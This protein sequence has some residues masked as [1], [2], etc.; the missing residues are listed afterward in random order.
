MEKLLIDKKELVFGMD[1]GTRTVV[2]VVGI[3]EGDLLRV[4]DVEVQEHQNRSMMDGQVHD[5]NGV[6][7]TANTVKIK[8]EERLGFK[9]KRVCI[10]AAGRVLR[11]S[12]IFVEKES[13]PIHEISKDQISTLEIEALL[14]AQNEFTYG[15]SQKEG[16]KFYC[17]GHTITNYHLD[18][19]P[20]MS[21]IGHRAR[22][23]GISVIAT[24]LP[25]VVVDSLY[26][27]MNKIGLEVDSLTLEP[28]AAINVSIPK[29]LRILNLALVDIGAGTSDIAI[30][31]DGSIVGYSM[32]PIAGDEVS[33]CIAQHYLVD[34]NTAE[35]IKMA[36]GNKKKSY[37]FEDILGKKYTIKPEEVIDIIKPAVENIANAIC[38]RIMEH[39]KKPTNAVFL[40][41][42]GSRVPGLTESIAKILG[43]PEERVA[44]RGRD[45]IKDIKWESTEFTGP[46]AIT[47]FG[48]AVTGMRQ[49]GNDFMEVTVNENPVKLFALKHLTIGDAI[50][51]AGFQP[52]QLIGR[53]GKGVIFQLNGIKKIVRGEPGKA[54][55]IYLNNYLVAIDAKVKRDDRIRIVEAKDGANARVYVKDF[56]SNTRRGSIS[57]N[58]KYKN[59]DASVVI[60]GVAVNLD[61]EIFEEDNVEIVE[62]DSV[63]K[64]MEENSLMLQ[65][66][67]IKVNGRVSSAY[68]KIKDGDDIKITYG[69]QIEYISDVKKVDY[70]HNYE[71]PINAPKE[72]E[73]L[74]SFANKLNNPANLKAITEMQS[75]KEGSTIGNSSLNSTSSINDPANEY[76]KVIVNGK[77]YFL[78]K[79]N[80]GYFFVEILSHINFNAIKEEGTL[81]MKLNGTKAG[82]TDSVRN[83]DSIEIYWEK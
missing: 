14:K 60:N 73:T 38:E 80:S 47:P 24:F 28:I 25:A 26:A 22:K 65:D 41:G 82:F 45:I 36:I 83:G 46:E 34:F 35:R 8:L 17:V 3:P 75:M 15:L 59:I 61:K 39:N 68:E 48:I 27:V 52:G 51:R 53:S 54:A 78:K 81:I 7:K 55:E 44:V 2:G 40:I 43:M 1:I 57:L 33:E 77:E 50:A 72:F 23:I 12:D 56:I 42:G 64:M 62:V 9:L 4:I 49:R 21:L 5:V 79:N 13:D 58:G 37:S 66:A 63:A 20:I 11:T 71:E 18:G 30:T 6:I 16:V 76:M 32:V 29:D 10:A 69:L 67:E 31:K 19:Y 74:D 70:S